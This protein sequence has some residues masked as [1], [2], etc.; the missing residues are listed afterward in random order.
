MTFKRK[1]II[2]IYFQ[3]KAFHHFSR[4]LDAFFVIASFPRFQFL[5]KDGLK[6]KS[7]VNDIDDTSSLMC[8]HVYFRQSLSS[9]KVKITNFARNKCVYTFIQHIRLGRIVV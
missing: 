8:V 3:I 7:T 6:S 1:R 4:N 5:T 2:F 9:I